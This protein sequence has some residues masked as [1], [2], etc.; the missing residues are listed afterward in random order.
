MILAAMLTMPVLFV[1]QLLQF[2]FNITDKFSLLKCSKLA[3][4]FIPPI[5][6]LDIII[7]MFGMPV[8]L[9]TQSLFQLFL[10]APVF[11]SKSVNLLCLW[12]LNWWCIWGCWRIAKI[13]ILNRSP[14]CVNISLFLTLCITWRAGQLTCFPFGHCATEN[15]R[16]IRALASRQK[17]QRRDPVHIVEKS[18]QW[19]SD[20]PLAPSAPPKWTM[21]AEARCRIMITI[22][23][24]I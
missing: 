11:F 7:I 4:I 10:Q 3:P 13:H 23:F 18:V 17:R 22:T 1:G 19:S 21:S 6:I 16:A 12:R 5:A 2:C 14:W 24:Q 20:L 9:Q 15:M 8:R